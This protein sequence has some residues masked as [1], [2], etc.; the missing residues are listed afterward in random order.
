MAPGWGLLYRTIAAAARTAGVS[1]PTIYN[2]LKGRTS[3]QVRWEALSDEE[4]RKVGLWADESGRSNGKR[5]SVPVLR[6]SDGL[7]FATLAEASAETG[8]AIQGR[9]GRPV[10]VR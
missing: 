6:L 5:L 9:Q 2:H 7:G 8:V 3:N 4:A 1:E 10:G